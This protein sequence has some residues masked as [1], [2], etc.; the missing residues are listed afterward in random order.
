MTKKQIMEMIKFLREAH[1][2]IQKF[3]KLTRGEVGKL[4][5]DH[6]I[7]L[8]E[9]IEINGMNKVKGRDRK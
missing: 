2:T 4:L 8:G 6:E 9:L 5:E 7:A 3:G 1:L